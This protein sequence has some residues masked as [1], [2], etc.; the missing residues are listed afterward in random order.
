[1]LFKIAVEMSV[2]NYLAENPRLNEADYIR[3]REYAADQVRKN[4]G[5]V[6]LEAA[7]KDKNVEDFF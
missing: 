4:R 6:S 5:W 1:M 3:L 2:N 7:L